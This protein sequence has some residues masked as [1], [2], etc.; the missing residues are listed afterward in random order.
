MPFS[1]LTEVNPWFNKKITEELR[2]Y[3]S[4]VPTIVI[5]PSLSP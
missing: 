5:K 1:G 2:S 4:D 3:S